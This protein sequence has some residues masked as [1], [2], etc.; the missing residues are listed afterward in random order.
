MPYPAQLQ[1]AREAKRLDLPVDDV[2]FFGS[3]N[4]KVLL[5]IAEGRIDVRALAREEVANRGLDR[6]GRWVGFRQAADDHGLMEV[7]ADHGLEM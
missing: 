5:A 2:M 6:T 4:T 3:V 7:E 1:A